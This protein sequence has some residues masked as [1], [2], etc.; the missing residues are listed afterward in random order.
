MARAELLL[1]S[2]VLAFDGD[3]IEAFGF[4]TGASQRIPVSTLTRM[5]INRDIL[6]LGCADHNILPISA[7]LTGE[8]V[9]DPATA[10]LLD[11]IRSAAPNLEES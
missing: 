8:E 9:E 3:V 7:V 10:K 4:T 5:E 1:K 11:A 6:T 2:G